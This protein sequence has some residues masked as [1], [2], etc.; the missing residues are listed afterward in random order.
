MTTE[1]LLEELRQIRQVQERILIM[2]D[3]A[4]P[5]IVDDTP[6]A[7][8][9]PAA[10]PS[11]AGVAARRKTV[12]LID[13]DEATVD[14]VSA[15]LSVV[16]IKVQAARDGHAGLAAI[17]RDRP[18]VIVIDLALGGNE[19]MAGKD[20]INMVRATMEWIDIPIVLFTNQPIA[21]LAEARALH[22]GDEF[23]PKAAG[24][25]VLATTVLSVMGRQAS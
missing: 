16:R 17:A 8:D 12:L 21:N 2:L 11:S 25:T 6:I 23:V 18:D 5:A 10:R 19:A 13:D 7:G 3:D 14:G 4:P 20:V 1:N 9:G 22:G 15:A 24:A